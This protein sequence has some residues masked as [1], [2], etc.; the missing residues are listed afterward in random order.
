M[1]KKYRKKKKMKKQICFLLLIC[2]AL[3]MGCSKEETFEDFFHKTMEKMHKGEKDF[4]Y[5]IIY[6]EM[7]V[8]H[9]NDA[10]AIFI[11]NNSHE[12]KIFIGYFEK[13]NNKW[14]WKRTRGA[15]WDSRLNWS[16]MNKV[17]YIYSG[18]INDNAISEVYAGDELA[19]IIEVDS[20]KRFWYA[21]SDAKEVQVKVVKND[22][23]QEVIEQIDKASIKAEY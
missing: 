13:E 23:T 3:L 5:S 20:N 8:V 12:E 15:E 22:G 19:K 17:P 14:N 1:I 21:I 11:E 10:I 18:A 6:K 4:S 16:S 7:N 2:I 9:K